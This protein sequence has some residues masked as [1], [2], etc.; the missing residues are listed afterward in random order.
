MNKKIIF[1]LAG[2]DKF[3]FDGGRVFLIEGAIEYAFSLCFGL[4]LLFYALPLCLAELASLIFTIVLRLRKSAVSLSFVCASS[5]FS[6][7][8]F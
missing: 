1:L 2:M 8:E 7:M 3:D 6:L 4:R 5:L